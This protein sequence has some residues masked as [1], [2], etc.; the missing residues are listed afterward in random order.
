VIKLEKRHSRE[1]T[2]LHE[3]IFQRKNQSAAAEA[4]PTSRENINH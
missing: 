4:V 3:Y 1:I 2:I